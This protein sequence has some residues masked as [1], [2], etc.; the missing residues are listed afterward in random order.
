M[1]HAEMTALIEEIT[2]TLNRSEFDSLNKTLGEIDVTTSEP[3]LIITYLR[4]S[5]VARTLLPE[6]QN[7]VDRT[8]KEFESRGMNTKRVLAGLL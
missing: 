7:L 6:W 1:T 3:D 4:T 8:A 5:Y 2:N